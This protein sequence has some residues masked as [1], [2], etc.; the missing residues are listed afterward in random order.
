MAALSWGFNI[1]IYIML[2]FAV[3]TFFYQMYNPF[4][5]QKENKLALNWD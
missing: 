3:L 4:R 2:G 1:F 5:K